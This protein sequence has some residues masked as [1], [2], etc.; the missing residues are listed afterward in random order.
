MYSQVFALSYDSSDDDYVAAIM[1][2][3]AKK[4]LAH[5][6]HSTS[7]VVKSTGLTDSGSV[8]NINRSLAPRRI[9][10]TPASPWNKGTDDKELIGKLR[11]AIACNG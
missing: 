6:V 3:T 10:A 9:K 11:T 1:S 7:G 2:E 5:N 8:C 4:S